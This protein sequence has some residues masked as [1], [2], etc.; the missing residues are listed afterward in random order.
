MSSA[1]DWKPSLKALLLIQWTDKTGSNRTFQLVEK[2]GARWKDI[3]TLLGIPQS[4]LD[5]WGAHYNN[6][7]PKCWQKVMKCW[8]KRRPSDEYPATWEGLY[9][10]LGTLGCAEEAR[11]MKD[12][13]EAVKSMLQSSHADLA[14]FSS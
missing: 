5:S 11:Q 9:S 14:S 10:L 2:A 3:G 8:L 4:K 7:A 12:T 6:K 1:N 13:V